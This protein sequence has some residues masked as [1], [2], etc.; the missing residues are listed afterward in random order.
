MKRGCVA[1]AVPLERQR[2]MK[3]FFREF[4]YRRASFFYSFFI[5]IYFGGGGGRLSGGFAKENV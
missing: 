1:T 2:A 4:D 5:Y 3:E